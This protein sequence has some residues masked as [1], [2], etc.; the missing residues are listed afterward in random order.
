MYY[1]IIS[2]EFPPGPGGIGKHAWSMAKA[3]I[4]NGVQVDVITNMDHADET[5]IASFLNSLPRGMS[6]YRVTRQGVQTYINR[7]QT[8]KRLCRDN[9]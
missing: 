7:L 1:L 4:H 2:S 8:I 6:V 9:R 5:T 3:L